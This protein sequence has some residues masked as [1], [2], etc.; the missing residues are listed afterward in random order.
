MCFRDLFVLKEKN[1]NKNGQPRILYL[2]KQSFRNEGEL[3]TPDKQKL[4]DLITSGLALQEMVKGV[5]PAEMKGY[6][7][8][9]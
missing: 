6:Y 7:L 3:K 5:L 9:I 2:A 1:K 4:R 8:V